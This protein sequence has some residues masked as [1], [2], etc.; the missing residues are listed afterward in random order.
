MFGRNEGL[1]EPRQPFHPD[2]ICTV[3]ELLQIRPD[4]GANPYWG[5]RVV[6]WWKQFG[7]YEGLCAPFANLPLEAAGECSWFEYY[8]RNPSVLFND[9][10]SYDQASAM[11]HWNMFGKNQGA[12]KPSVGSDVKSF[13]YKLSPL[14][15]RLN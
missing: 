4:V 14:A 1:C 10:Y 7:K 15:D 5:K 8:M 6:E 13:Q 3:D 9:N 2:E 11:R 12:C